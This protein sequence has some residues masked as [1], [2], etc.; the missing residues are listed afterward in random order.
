M[1]CMDGIDRMKGMKSIQ[2]RAGIELNDPD[3]WDKIDELNRSRHL[4]Q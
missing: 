1:K 3:D 2:H 4:C